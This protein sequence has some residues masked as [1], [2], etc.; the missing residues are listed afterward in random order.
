MKWLLLERCRNVCNFLVFHKL[1][2]QNYKYCDLILSIMIILRLHTLQNLGKQLHKQQW[3]HIIVWKNS[4]H[5]S[6][7]SIG[8][9]PNPT[10][11]K[12]FLRFFL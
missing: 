3:L 4:S 2:P 8:M 6:L 9:V 7:S 12:S 11:N 10:Q 1:V 5:L